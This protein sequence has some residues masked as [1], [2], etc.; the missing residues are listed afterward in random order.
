MVGAVAWSAPAIAL[1]TTA[2]A[3]A[4]S[5]QGVIVFID[6]ADIIG[7]GGSEVFTCQ[8]TVP[9]GGT[10]PATVTVTYSRPGIASGPVTVPTGGQT[11][12]SFTVTAGGSAGS[13]DIT[14]RAPDYV[15]AVTTLDVTVDYS[16]IV[17]SHVTTF[18]YTNASNVLVSGFGRRIESAGG[19]QD[20]YEGNTFLHP[21]V[22]AGNTLNFG[23]HIWRGTQNDYRY[24]NGGHIGYRL[25]VFAWGDAALSWTDSGNATGFANG[26]KPVN[27]TQIVGKSEAPGKINYLHDGAQRGENALLPIVRTA[28]PSASHGN[29]ILAL[30]FPNRFPNYSA[31]FYFEC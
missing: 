22:S 31:L 1:A 28:P 25:D 9:P 30:T 21:V 5:T 18:T 27:G 10:V 13:T 4:A 11:I 24:V 29:L 16:D 23:A 6:P 19:V 20:V 7:A 17:M 12:F 3:Y 15:S 26:G 8:L 2:P 14:V